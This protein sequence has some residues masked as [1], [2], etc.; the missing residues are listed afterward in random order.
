MAD[1]QHTYCKVG[2][3]SEDRRF[4]AAGESLARAVGLRMWN[5]RQKLKVSSRESTMESGA[6][7]KRAGGEGEEVIRSAPFALL[8]FRLSSAGQKSGRVVS[9]PDR[10]ECASGTFSTPP[11]SPRDAKGGSHKSEVQGRVQVAKSLPPVENRA[12]SEISGFHPLHGRNSKRERRGGAFSRTK[13]EEEEDISL[14]RRNFRG[15]V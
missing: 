6:K 8:Q 3:D 4:G 13:E 9:Q 15:G 14:M 12:R 7:G 10:L 2:L 11:P 5:N 1:W